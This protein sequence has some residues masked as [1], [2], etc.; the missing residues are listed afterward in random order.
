MSSSKDVEERNRIT[1]R[2][3][4]DKEL[5][6][7]EQRKKNAEEQKK[8]TEN[9][10]NAR[11]EPFLKR[12]E[13]W[14]TSA[15]HSTSWAFFRTLGFLSDDK[16]TEALLCCVCHPDSSIV[17]KEI[18]STKFRGRKG[19]LKYKSSSGTTALKNHVEKFHKS[20]RQVERENNTE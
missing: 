5:T 3:D 4:V 18:A 2:A 10:F 14:R 8:K 17:G 9:A 19:L 20:V 1:A 11:M 7:E 16:K 13:K 15:R 12:L 6:E